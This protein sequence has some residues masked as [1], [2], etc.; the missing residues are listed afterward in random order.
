M[1]SIYSFGNSFITT[2]FIFLS[3]TS[4]LLVP[5][6]SLT[7]ITRAQVHITTHPVPRN[8][9]DS[10]LVLAALQKFG[11]VVTFR[12]LKVSPSKQPTN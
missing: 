11:E 8:L 10:K 2:S 7:T 1:P 9:G 4:L 6:A 12:N 3:T 5:M